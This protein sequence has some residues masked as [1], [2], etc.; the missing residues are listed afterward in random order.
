MPPLAAGVAIM[1]I[2]PRVC[3][4]DWY[5]EEQKSSRRKSD[6]ARWRDESPRPHDPAGDACE[7]EEL[8]NDGK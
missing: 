1:R 6:A 2:G 5:P 8:K 7:I 4:V 3:L